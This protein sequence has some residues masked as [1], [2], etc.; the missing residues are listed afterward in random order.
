MFMVHGDRDHYSAMGSVAL[1]TEL[2]KRKIPAQ[3]F[4][5]A[6]GGHGIGDGAN[7]TGWQRRIIDWIES[8]GY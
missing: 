4:V 5:Y 2:H 8:I 1:Y 7:R 6:H 3:L